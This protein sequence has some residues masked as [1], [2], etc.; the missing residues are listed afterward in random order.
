MD[1]MSRAITAAEAEQITVRL[2]DE[3]QARQ[4]RSA[5]V[6]AFHAYRDVTCV[7]VDESLHAEQIDG[8]LIIQRRA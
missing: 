5:L 7:M 4:D 1:P 3:R 6:T 8:V 2:L